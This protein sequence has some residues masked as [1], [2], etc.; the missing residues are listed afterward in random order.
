MSSKFHFN[1]SWID[2]LTTAPLRAFS[3][4]MYFGNLLFLIFLKDFIYLFLERG[5]G[6]EK[7]R[8]RIINVWLSLTCPLLGTWPETQ[9][10]AL[11]G[12]RTGD[13]PVCRPA[14]NSLSCT[15]QGIKSKTFLIAHKALQDLAPYPHLHILCPPS[16]PPVSFILIW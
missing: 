10:C 3:I 8:E 12:N 5:E 7:E 11:T 14:L 15:S 2:F 1:H 13:L 4:L 9:A 16:P 6:R